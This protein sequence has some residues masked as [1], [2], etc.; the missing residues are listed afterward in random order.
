MGEE[1]RGHGVQLDRT[2]IT[3]QADP[4][5]EWDFLRLELSARDTMVVGFVDRAWMEAAGQPDHLMLPDVGELPGWQAAQAALPA[6]VDV[7]WAV[8]VVEG[9][10]DGDYRACSQTGSLRW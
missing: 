2:A 8:G 9:A 3:W 7:T 5:I 1:D 10:F 6:G 4:Q